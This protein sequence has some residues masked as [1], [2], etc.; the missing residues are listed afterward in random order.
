[1]SYRQT[2]VAGFPAIA[3]RSNELEAIVIPSLGSKISNLRRLRGRE[4][5]WRNQQIPLALPRDGASYVETADSGGWDECF[6]TV[7]ASPMPGAEATEPLLP[8]HGELWSSTWTNEVYDHA[9][10]TTL[11]SRVEGRRLPYSFVRHLTLPTDAAEMRLQYQLVHRGERDFPFIWSAHPLFNIQP[12][13]QLEL[14]GVSRVRVDAVHGRDD[15]APGLVVPWPLDG[16]GLGYTHGRTRSWAAKLFAETSGGRM[17]LTD[18]SLGEQLEMTVDPAAVPQIGIWINAGGWAPSGLQPYDNLALE[19]C[20]GAPDRLDRAVEQWH[21]ASIL[22]VGEERA[23][24]V[25]VALRDNS[26]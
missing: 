13:T 24:T 10:G 1:M 14:P 18:P 11:S 25:T 22:R 26:D 6:P 20:I 23:W 4:W 9:G 5:L 7:G 8:D 16:D 17:I 21:M 15:L 12:G 3:L 2:T 19:P